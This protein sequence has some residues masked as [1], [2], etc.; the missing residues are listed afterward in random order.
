MRLEMRGSDLSRYK[1]FT[2]RS[3]ILGGVQLA[4]VSGLVARLYQL[5]V[6]HSDKYRMQAEDNRVNYQLLAPPRGR[7]L[8]RFGE[9][10]AVNRQNYRIILIPEQTQSVEAT[11]AALERIVKVGE[12]E[13][14]RILREVRRKRSFVPIT[15]RENLTWSEV[16]RIE[17]NAPNLP[18]LMIDVGESRYYP[19]GSLAAHLVGYVAAVSEEELSDDPLLSL[20]GFRIGKNGVEKT[21]DLALRGSAGSRQVEVN[22][23]GRIIRELSRRDGQPG[24]DYALTIDIG[25]QEF[26]TTRLGQDSAAAAVLDVH[27][28]DILALASTPGFDPNAFGVGL[29]HEEWQKL[30]TDKRAPLT[31]KAISGQYPPGSIFKLMATLAALEGNH[32]TPEHRF[33]CPGYY[34]FGNA[35]F[36]CWRERGHGWMRMIDAITQSCDVYFYDVARRVGIDALGEMARRFGFGERLG[37]GLPGEQGGF[38]PTREWKQATY[39]EPWQGGETLIIG[40]GQGYL[41]ATPLQLAVMTARLANGGVAV[42]PRLISHVIRGGRSEPVPRAASPSMNISPSSLALALKG[43][44]QVTNDPHGTAYRARISDPAMIMAGKTGSSQVRRITK[45]ER[46]NKIKKNEDLPWEQRDHALFVGFAPVDAPRYAVSVIVEHGGSGA[47]VAAPVA[48]DILWET[49][50]RDPSRRTPDEATRDS[51]DEV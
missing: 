22:A 3:L 12:D 5:Q 11:L 1:L 13:K 28:G 45:S 19:Y 42:T 15:V 23:L 46:L 43:M 29:S 35:R 17:V 14:E 9:V 41:L 38:V 6:V 50:K 34:D 4:L 48:R 31:N 10:L 25:L 51:R 27:T 37:L 39:G 20:P 7:I 47:R 18:G 36:H 8:D 24:D 16:S 44:M 30:T 40:I 21:Y 49:Q 26:A 32:I 2:R 33:F